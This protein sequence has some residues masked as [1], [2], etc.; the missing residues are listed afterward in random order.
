MTETNCNGLSM[1]G[2]DTVTGHV[3]GPS[4]LIKIRLK[5]IPEMGYTVND[6]PYP[7]GELLVKGHGV[8]SGYFRNPEKTAEAFDKD[9]WLKTGDVVQVYE[10][11]SVKIIDR[12]KNIFKLSQGEYIAP[13]KVEG[14]FTL[15]SLIAQSFLFGN[16]LNSN[17]VA[18]VVPDEA[19]VM[20]W[21]QEKNIEGDFATVCKS[22]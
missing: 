20:P 2:I 22:P 14:V 3:G 17:C 5:S 18:I 10:N 1:R 15:S 16:S 11:G 7:R 13:E 9:G 8:F 4:Q 6:K 19:V 12:S 21:A